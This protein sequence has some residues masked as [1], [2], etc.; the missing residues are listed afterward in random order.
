[1]VELLLWEWS[2][3]STSTMVHANMLKTLHIHTIVLF[4]IFMYIN[5]L[6]D[7]FILYI[8]I[9]YTCRYILILRYSIYIS[10]SKTSV[11]CYFQVPPEPNIIVFLHMPYIY[12]N[13][14]LTF[15]SSPF[16]STKGSFNKESYP[17][18]MGLCKAFL[19]T[20]AGEVEMVNMFRHSNGKARGMGVPILEKKLDMRKRKFQ[21]QHESSRNIRK[22][23]H[24]ILHRLL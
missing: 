22:F 9:Y 20:I 16:T 21:D 5:L 19:L 7:L 8:Y 23:C 10:F 15:T 18:K 17:K 24:P 4:V 12:A 6:I 2:S 3:S 14:I 11:R 13:F 1:M